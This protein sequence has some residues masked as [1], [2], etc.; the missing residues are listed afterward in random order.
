MGGWFSGA[1]VLCRKEPFFL[2]VL[3]LLSH[4]ETKLLRYCFIVFFSYDVFAWLCYQGNNWLHR[5]SGEVYCL[6]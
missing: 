6:L 3:L 5:M 2:V 4:A 1:L